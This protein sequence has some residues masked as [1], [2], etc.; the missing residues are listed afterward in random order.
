M[1][2][3][4]NPKE[5]RPHARGRKRIYRKRA[6]VVALPVIEEH[7]KILTR[8]ARGMWGALWWVLE[9]PQLVRAR[10]PGLLPEEAH[11]FLPADAREALR[12]QGWL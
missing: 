4:L 2:S 8:I 9:G 12:R 3:V 10:G 6:T 11:E 1:Q 5:K 7:P